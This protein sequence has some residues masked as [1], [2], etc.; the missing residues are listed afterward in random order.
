VE[1]AEVQPVGI[2]EYCT[3]TAI[4]EMTEYCPVCGGEIKQIRR[5]QFAHPLR[6]YD[7]PCGHKEQAL[8]M[9]VSDL[10]DDEKLAKYFRNKN[11]ISRLS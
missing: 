6:T 3:G 7:F 10:R 2:G 1:E 5:S 9:L 4:K 11:E 8:S